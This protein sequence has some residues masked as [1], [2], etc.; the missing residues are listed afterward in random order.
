[1]RIERTI[2]LPKISEIEA[3]WESSSQEARLEGSWHNSDISQNDITACK[4]QKAMQKAVVPARI[5]SQ[6]QQT[7][8][9]KKAVINTW[10]NT[11]HKLE[12]L[13]GLA[14]IPSFSF[15]AF[16]LFGLIVPAGLILAFIVLVIAGGRLT[17]EAESVRAA[18]RAEVANFDPR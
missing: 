1:M 16:G 11:L 17:E 13:C 14:I 5:D 2:P 4:L 9:P 3:A 15:L 10:K 8:K 7:I 18:R 12:M 6:N